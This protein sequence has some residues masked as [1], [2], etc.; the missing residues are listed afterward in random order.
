M[1]IF[2]SILCFILLLTTC[3]FGFLAY[4]SGN[5]LLNLEDN[6]Q[7]AIDIIEGQNK[8]MF[9]IISAKNILNDDDTIRMFMKEFQ[10]TR[11]VVTAVLSEIILST[12]SFEITIGE[13]VLALAQNKEQEQVDGFKSDST[14]QEK[15]N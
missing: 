6:S 5:M 8:K 2:L 13:E 12:E 4:R 9:E 11:S 10:K 1:I 14:G 7:L 3:G 15:N